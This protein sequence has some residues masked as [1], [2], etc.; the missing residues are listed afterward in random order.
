MKNRKK[1]KRNYIGNRERKLKG[2]KDL[3]V[4]RKGEAGRRKEEGGRESRPQNLYV[5][6]GQH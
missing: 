4:S 1:K 5:S 6:L 2:R 3:G